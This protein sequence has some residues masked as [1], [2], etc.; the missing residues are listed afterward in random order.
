LGTAYTPGLRVSAD[1]VVE[2]LRRLPL[3]GEV[4]VEAGAS[5]LPD[6]VVARTELPGLMQTVR[7]AERLGVE[8]KDVAEAL[9]VRQGDRVRKG[10]LLA[11]TKGLFGRLFR[12]Q[13]NS[14]TDGTVELISPLTGHVGIREAPTPVERTAYIRGVVSRVLPEEGVV[15]TCRGALAQGIFGVGGERLGEIAVTAGPDE[16]LTEQN[17]T[18][19]HRGKIVVGGSGVTGG[20]LRRAAV[21]GLAGV[22]CGG[23]V[24]RELMDYLA[25][26][27]GR[28]GYDIGVAITGQEP[29]PFTLVLTEGFGDIR[30][31]ARTYALLKSLVGQV[32]SI[33]GATQIRA[34]VIRPEVIVPFVTDESSSLSSLPSDL[35]SESGQLIIGAPIRM[36]REPY[37][38]LLGTVSGL[39]SEPVK[40]ESEAVVRILQATL[41]DGRSITVPRANVEL[42]ETT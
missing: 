37:F 36:I 34:G 7:M 24:D 21:V 18:E 39:P 20:A 11:Q 2:K 32:A 17:L 13:V 31:A 9:C 15:V 28:P 29:I 38:G 25:E 22:V 14:P 33:N 16:M 6:T 8:P 42:I 26:A 19:A 5:V 1:T 4:L 10:D 40:V 23:V 27:L 35:P 3:K 41:E 12:T 30:M